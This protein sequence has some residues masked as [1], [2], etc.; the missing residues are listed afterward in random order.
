MTGVTQKIADIAKHQR[1]HAELM[2][3]EADMKERQ[4]IELSI[5]VAE[6]RQRAARLRMTLGYSA[7]V[8]GAAG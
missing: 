2:E 6:L 4:S 8:S 7:L 5:E 3:A 1:E